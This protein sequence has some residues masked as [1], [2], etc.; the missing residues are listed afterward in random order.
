MHGELLEVLVDPVERAPLRVE[1]A[2]AAGNGEIA[3]ASLVAGD[4]ARYDV[5]ERVPRMVPDAQSS[6]S[7][8]E[9]ATQRSFGAKWEQYQESDK[10]HLAEFQYAWFD[11]RFGFGDEPAFAEFLRG[12]R[13]VL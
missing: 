5:R 2:Q 9:G 11:E 7:A 8:D 12:R 4:G 3:S 1:D 6:V 13:W 10:Q